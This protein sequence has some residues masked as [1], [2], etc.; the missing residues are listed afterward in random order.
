MRFFS[1]CNLNNEVSVKKCGCE[2]VWS[3]SGECRL[4]LARVVAVQR[5]TAKPEEHLTNFRST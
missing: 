3:I 2:G 4:P 5:V 1:Q